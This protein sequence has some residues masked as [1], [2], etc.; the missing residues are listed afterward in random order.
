MCDA[1]RN[2]DAKVH[3]Q[4]LQPGSAITN[5]EADIHRIE[6]SVNNATR[7]VKQRAGEILINAW[8]RLLGQ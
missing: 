7:S 4:S 5:I 3:G 2:T 6:S 1:H 8:R